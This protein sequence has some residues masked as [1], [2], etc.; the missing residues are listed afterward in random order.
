MGERSKGSPMITSN[1]TSPNVHFSMETLN[2]FKQF[3]DNATVQVGMD[4]FED[5]TRV[6]IQAKREL[7]KALIDVAVDTMTAA[8]D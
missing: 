1:G 7:G 6:A 5:A 2:L 3:L 8:G 4:D